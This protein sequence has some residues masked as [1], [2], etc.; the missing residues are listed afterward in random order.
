MDIGSKKMGDVEVNTEVKEAPLS[1]NANK[2]MMPPKPKLITP[3]RTANTIFAPVTFCETSPLDFQKANGA[4]IT[5]VPVIRRKLAVIGSIFRM[6]SLT[7]IVLIPEAIPEAIIDSSRNNTPLF[8]WAVF[9]E[10]PVNNRL[11]G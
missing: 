6:P 5:V 10:N 9:T 4:S 8:S 7:A 11:L 3:L 1:F 2:Y